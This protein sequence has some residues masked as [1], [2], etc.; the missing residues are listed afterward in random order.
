MNMDWNRLLSELRCPRTV[1]GEAVGSEHEEF[2]SPFQADYDRVVFSTPFRR[3]ARKTQ[4]HPLVLNDHVHT[5]LT[6]SLEVCSVGRSLAQRLSHFLK[7]RGELPTGRSADDLLWIVQAA[8][9]AHD[10]G[11][12]PFG[13]A[14]EYA[15]REWV[16]QHEQEIFGTCGA[17]LSNGTR[18][19][20]RTFE[21]NAQ[22]FR[23]TARG[24]NPQPGYMRL[25]FA[26]LGAMIKYPWTSEDDRTQE[27][28][29]YNVFSSEHRLFQILASE[30]GM[31]QAEGTVA[32]HPLSFL[33][34][35]ADDTCYEI[36]DLE[37]AVEMGIM[38]EDSVKDIYKSLFSSEN[39]ARSPLS[40][41]RGKAIGSL[42]D[43]VW[44][45][46][47]SDYANI[48]AGQR[49]KA[50]KEGF[51]AELKETI[52]KIK[53]A[54][55]KIFADRTKVAAELGAYKALGRIMRA[56]CQACSELSTKG[57]YGRVGFLS[58]R[59]FALAW[60]DEYAVQ[61]EGQ[62][63]EWWLHQILDYVSGL[64]DNYARQISREI[65]GT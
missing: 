33:T 52:G 51:P 5:R 45:V 21:G 44:E 23:M 15:I 55:H 16:T 53:G 54:Y 43:H 2:R 60:T 41:L 39:D 34:E 48:M 49:T 62:T 35:A 11:N 32:R 64:T 47:V 56:L 31:Q 12:P 36:L 8:C 61:N 7:S 46:F 20:L 37:D 6:H 63:Y 65:E 29:K 9:L 13:H 42:I 19:D 58:K 14:G 26:T 17:E 28:H 3:L 38:A 22:G 57:M 4:V 50:L 30:T 59:C 40:V 27:K 24:D 18:S 1:D 25:T 10:I